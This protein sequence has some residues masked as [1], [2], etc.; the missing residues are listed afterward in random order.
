[1]R[2]GKWLYSAK[3]ISLQIIPE[4]K[5]NMVDWLFFRSWFPFKKICSSNFCWI[6][7]NSQLTLVTPWLYSLVLLD[8]HLF[9]EHP[10]LGPTV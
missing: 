5:R 1:M 4:K 2:L 3:R 10:E 8:V 9:V 6:R 7:N